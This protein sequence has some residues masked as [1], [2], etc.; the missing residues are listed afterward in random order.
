MNPRKCGLLFLS[1]LVA[2]SVSG[3]ASTQGRA[4]PN[5]SSIELKE[6]GINLY[7]PALWE[8]NFDS[9]RR[10]HL[11]AKGLTPEG[12]HASLEYRGIPQTQED[13]DLY[14]EGWYNAMATN[15]DGFALIK[16][17]KVAGESGDI[18]HFEATFHEGD[19]VKRV[20][21]RLRFREGRVH[22]VYYIAEDKDFGSF[23]EILEDMDQMHK[24][25]RP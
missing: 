7:Y 3:C 12:A 10:L 17:Q 14:A 13:V 23:R 21:G 18:Y 11:I 19:I 6:F 2:I 22:A 1:L 4:Y 9:R 24:F 5:F 25:F 15:F 20:I 16:R 8:L